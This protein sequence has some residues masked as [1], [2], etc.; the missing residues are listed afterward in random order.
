MLTQIENKNGIISYDS[1]LVEQLIN[2][3]L[4]PFK[5]DYKLIKKEYAMETEGVSL[6]LE[7][8]LKFGTSIATFSSYV[9]NNIGRRIEENFELPVKKVSMHISGIYS[10]KLM[11]RDIR[12]EYNNKSE[13]TDNRD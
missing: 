4:A 13:I 3:A 12:F 6:F 7:L 5:G 11:K 9:L 1:S 8:Q 2:D 10:K